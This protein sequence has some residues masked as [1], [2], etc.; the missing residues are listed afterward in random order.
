MVWTFSDVN[1]S[2]LLTWAFH[3][4]G[5]SF[6]PFPIPHP[7]SGQGSNEKSPKESHQIRKMEEDRQA[8]HSLNNQELAI[9]SNFLFINHNYNHQLFCVKDTNMGAPR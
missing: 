1:V 3:E 4:K 6:R 5:K 7:D 9:W 8:K 2:E